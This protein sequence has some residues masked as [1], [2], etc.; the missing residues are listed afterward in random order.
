MTAALVVSYQ[1]PA[2]MMADLLASL[3]GPPVLAEVLVVDNGSTEREG[4][5]AAEDAGARVLRMPRNQG[6]S[7]AVNRGMEELAGHEFVLV[8]NFDL[9]LEPGAVE[10]MVEVAEARPGLAGVAPKILLHDHPGHIDAVGTQVHPG[11]LA[12]NRGIGQPD[13]G[14]FDAVE[15]VMGLCFGA[16]LVRT[17]AFRAV[18][19]MWE[20]YFLYFEDVDWC[21]RARLAGWSFATAPAAS[22]VH[23]HSWLLRQRPTADKYAWVQSNLLLAI[24]RLLEPGKAL[25]ETVRR[26]RQL[27]LRARAEPALALATRQVLRRWLRLLPAALASRAGTQRAR[28][29]P[30]SLLFAFSEGHEGCFDDAGYAPLEGRR[31]AA[32]A[33]GWL[34]TLGW[35]DADREAA[36][37]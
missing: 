33:R 9:V 1:A 2:G 4:L 8:L 35:Q 28:V 22:A 29:V 16:A 34:W 36:L 11:M 15:P 21:W 6:F 19:P 31:P 17:K 30:D 37:E 14:Q 10:A 7:A 20:P 24:A 12:A 18:G 3:P 5:A 32:A 26:W 13:L 23:R 25:L 27:R